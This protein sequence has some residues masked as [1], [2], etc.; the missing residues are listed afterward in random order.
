MECIFHHSIFKNRLLTRE[1]FLKTTKKSE[2][3]TH[4][5]FLNRHEIIKMNIHIH[6]IEQ[7]FVY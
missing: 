6:Y 5:A 7:Y 3:I 1:A 2:Q 4:N